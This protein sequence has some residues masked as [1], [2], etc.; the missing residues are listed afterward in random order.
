MATTNVRFSSVLGQMLVGIYA[1]FTRLR[2][3]TS[4]NA[5][6]GIGTATKEIGFIGGKK[7]FSQ[8]SFDFVVGAILDYWVGHV[9]PATRAQAL[10]AADGASASPSA[11][12]NWA[13]SFLSTEH[14]QEA[15]EHLALAISISPATGDLN[16][17]QTLAQNKGYATDEVEFSFIPKATAKGSAAGKPQ[18]VLKKYFNDPSRAEFLKEFNGGVPVQEF[19]SLSASAPALVEPE[20]VAP[21]TFSA[22]N[23][24]TTKFKK[25]YTVPVVLNPNDKV[26]AEVIAKFTAATDF[27]AA[28]AI[29]ADTFTTALPATVTDLTKLNTHVASLT[30][31][32][33]KA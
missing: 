28:K 14:A 27:D 5:G 21:M 22:T 33:L 6:N 15:C 19:P 30:N 23:R 7:F 3:T 8:E 29:F 12:A 4:I 24:T 32:A 9:L 26:S 11:F 31:A 17:M 18:E 20:V 1:G 16:R 2:D 10:I 13:V 25:T